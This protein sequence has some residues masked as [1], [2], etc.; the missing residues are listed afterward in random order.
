MTVTLKR[1]DAEIYVDDLPNG[2]K[3]ITVNASDKSIFVPFKSCET[4]YPLELIE[5]ILD[6]KGP[7]Y[8]CDE[9]MR[10]EDPT[11]V[12][13]I[14]KASILGYLSEDDFEHKRLLDFGCSS[15]ASTMIL[16]RMFPKTQIVGIDIDNAVLSVAR[17]R[18]HYYGFDDVTFLLSPSGTQVPEKIGRFDFVVLSAVYEHLLPDERGTILPQIWSVIKPGGVLFVNQTPNRYFPVET[19]TTHLPL[20]N[21]LPDQMALTV[22]HRFSKRVKKNEPWE[23]LLREGIRG[24]TEH[25]ILELSRK[26]CHCP[27]ELLEPSRMGFRDRID[28][29]Y[30]MPAFG[31]DGRLAMLRPIFKLAFKGLKL[32]SGVTFLPSFAIAIRRVGTSF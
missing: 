2:K 23:M 6:V 22:A 17:Q 20:I 5:L 26:T 14:L 13:N 31:L 12:E 15:G 25:E 28:L 3:R 27:V 1:H 16:R 4:S 30:A 11:H 8:L 7:G 21:Y 29:W 24:A 19:H 9:I 32:V 10:D 18:A